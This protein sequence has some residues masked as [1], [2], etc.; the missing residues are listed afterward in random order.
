MDPLSSS[1]LL[2]VSKKFDYKTTC[3]RTNH[4]FMIFFTLTNSQ[5]GFSLSSPENCQF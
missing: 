3:Y 1:L 5:P 2:F 4:V